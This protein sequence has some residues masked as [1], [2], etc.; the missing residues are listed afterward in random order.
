MALLSLHELARHG[1]GEAQRLGRT[2]G[3]AQ[4]SRCFKEDAKA[5]PCVQ[6][7]TKNSSL[8][9]HVEGSGAMRATADLNGN[10]ARPME[11]MEAF[12]ASGQ[13]GCSWTSS[14]DGKDGLQPHKKVA[15]AYKQRL[16]LLLQPISWS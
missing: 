3:Y 15:T 4:G 16:C 13:L 6:V 7:D 11:G 10:L 2:S 8:A 5:S 9:A 14:G 12:V 1:A